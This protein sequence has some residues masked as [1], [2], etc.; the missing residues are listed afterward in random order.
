MTPVLADTSKAE[1][2]FP[3]IDPFDYVRSVKLALQR[4]R[5]RAVETRWSNAL[6]DSDNFYLKDN[7]GLVREVRSRFVPTEPKHVFRSFASIGGERGWLVYNWLWKI[8]GV[9]DQLVGGPGLRRGRRHP[10]E[11]L[12]GEALDFWR[13]EKVE[14]NHRLVLRAEMK[15]PGEAWLSWEAR[16]VEGGSELTQTALFSPHGF[17]GFVYWYAMYPAHRFIFS[18]MC[19][20][21]ADDALTMASNG[22]AEMA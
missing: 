8:R 2:Y 5:E 22:S 9:M 11:V 10:V 3:D 19:K 6:S 21:I 14:E 18:D 15:V 16:E 20:A 17:W 13:V 4:I 12:P 7:E 1:K